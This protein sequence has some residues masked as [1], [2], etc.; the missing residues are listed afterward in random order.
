MIDVIELKAGS[1]ISWG[2]HLWRVDVVWV[3]GAVIQCVG[4][5]GDIDTNG[6]WSA[7]M[8]YDESIFEH[9]SIYACPRH[10]VGLVD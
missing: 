5:V 1:I 10:A 2:D 8:K 4:R 9:G 3:S 7:M 6:W